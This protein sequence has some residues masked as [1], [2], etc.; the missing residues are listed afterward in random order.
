MLGT[1]FDDSTDPGSLYQVALQINT[2]SRRLTGRG[3]DTGIAFGIGR[4]LSEKERAD[5]CRNRV[6]LEGRVPQIRHTR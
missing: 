5:R 2:P 3:V 1:S 6:R 4:L